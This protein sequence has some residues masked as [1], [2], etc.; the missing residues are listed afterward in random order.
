MVSAIGLKPV[1][2][3]KVIIEQ[4]HNR[5]RLKQISKTLKYTNAKEI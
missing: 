3:R 4:T 5:T 1:E 2:C